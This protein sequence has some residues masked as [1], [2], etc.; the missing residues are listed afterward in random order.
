MYMQ[1]VNNPMKNVVIVI[2]TYQPDDKFIHF[3]SD[4]KE[5]G[6]E[7]IIVVNDGSGE[8]YD[9][10]FDTAKEDY[11]CHVVEHPKNMGYGK[12]LKTGNETFLKLYQEDHDVVGLIHCDC[13]GQHGIKDINH[14]AELLNEQTD[15]L[16]VG[17]RSFQQDHVPLKNRLGNTITGFIFKHFLH[18]P[19]SD[20]QC[21][22]RGIP[23]SLVKEATNINGDGFEYTSELLIHFHHCHIPILPV[24]IET[25]YINNNE[26]T[27][28]NPLLDS[29][30]VYSV[31]LKFLFSSLSSTIIDVLLFYLFLKMT[32]NIVFSTYLARVIS[33]TYVYFVNKYYTFKASSGQFQAMQFIVLCVVQAS[34]SAFFTNVVYQ[35]LS[36]NPVFIKII[37]DT[38]LFIMSYLVQK[39]IIFKK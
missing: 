7:R 2:P 39:K 20:T 25:I 14:F 33:C 24:S 36:F 1:C 28:F 34:L 22:L 5:N 13:D 19:I 6:Y 8:V 9:H 32:N 27:H 10:Y 35:R 21:G 4:L 12:A 17:S 15:T 23:T 31:I 16:F 11:Y 38:S 26:T 3:L 37:V 29:I 30:R 18:I